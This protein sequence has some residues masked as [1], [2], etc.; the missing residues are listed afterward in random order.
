MDWIDELA[1]T[2]GVDRLGDQ[3]VEELLSAAGDV[4]H[5]VER[6]VTPLSTF[7]LGIAVGRGASLKGARE[8]LVALLPPEP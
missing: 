4:A 3:E 5:R 8:K 7:L 2:L 6:K 1:N